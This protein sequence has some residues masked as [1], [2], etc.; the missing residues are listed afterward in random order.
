MAYP[1]TRLDEIRRRQGPRRP[2]GLICK[3]LEVLRDGREDE[4][5]ARAGEASQSHALEAMLDLQVGKAH[6]HFLALIARLLKLRC[7]L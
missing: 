4:L 5:V 7:A 6:L 2:P 3:R 1:L